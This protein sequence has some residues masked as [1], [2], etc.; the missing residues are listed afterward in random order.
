MRRITLNNIRTVKDEDNE[1]PLRFPTKQAAENYI[2]SKLL[3]EEENTKMD[4][5]EIGAWISTN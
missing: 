2:H 1:V 3:V 4:R 5:G